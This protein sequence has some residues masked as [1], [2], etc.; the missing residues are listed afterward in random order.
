MSSRKLL[1]INQ[2]AIVVEIVEIIFSVHHPNVL[3]A[4]SV[5]KLNIAGFVG[6]IGA[7]RV[8]LRGTLGDG[9]VA[10]KTVLN[11]VLNPITR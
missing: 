5:K 8:A 6:T 9:G 2:Q 11:P 7:D 10:T 3:H 1:G 4:W